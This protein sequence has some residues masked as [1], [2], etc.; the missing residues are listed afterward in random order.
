MALPVVTL[1]G[2]TS[3][4]V[5]SLRKQPSF[6]AEREE[7]RLFSQACGKHRTVEKINEN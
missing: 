6:F 1:S 4:T 2:N 3:N 7:G 5:V